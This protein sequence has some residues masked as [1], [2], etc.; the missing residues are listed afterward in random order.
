M[1]KLNPILYIQFSSISDFALGRNEREECLVCCLFFFYYSNPTF[2]LIIYQ[3][4]GKLY[5]T[6]YNIAQLIGWGYILYGTVL[7]YVEGHEPS[8]VWSKVGIALMYFQNA[9]L[10]EV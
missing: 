3:F 8:Q 4:T 5:L 9:A 7:N 10:L 2:N 6:L 1:T